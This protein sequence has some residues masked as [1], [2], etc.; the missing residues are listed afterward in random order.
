MKLTKSKLID[1][2]K[3]GLSKLGYRNVK[4]T[5]TGAQGLY[6]KQ[7][8]YNM[9]LTIGLT[10]SRHY[11]SKFTASYY[12][13]KVTTWGVVWG[14][15][16]R[17]SY[18]RVGSFLTD[19]ERKEL[20]E[21]RYLK[22]GVK[23]SW[24]DEEDRNAVANFIN[25]VRI[26]EDRFLSQTELYN[27]IV[28]STDVNELA[29]MSKKVIQKINSI[30]TEQYQYRFIPKKTIDDIPIEWFKAAEK[31]IVEHSSILNVNT[32]KHLAGDAHRQE[33]IGNVSKLLVYQ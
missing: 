21:E 17:N 1:L 19:K 5:I 30:K 3:R 12:L 9:Y 24:W 10:I 32:V 29:A 31:I 8:E 6:I 27:D 22:A 20:L 25:A 7:V 13:S 16:P 33:L 23:D 4:D 14:D 15:I 2:T 28:H 11:D 18:E 26:T